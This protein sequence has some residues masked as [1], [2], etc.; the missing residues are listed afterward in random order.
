MYAS[1]ICKV[2]FSSN[3]KKVATVS[4][5][6]IVKGIKKG[7]AVIKVKVTAKDMDYGLISKSFKIKV[8][9]GKR[10]VDLSKFKNSKKRLVN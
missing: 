10:K 1:D 2:S 3:K 9:I 4:N 5:K 7:K 6:G 8:T